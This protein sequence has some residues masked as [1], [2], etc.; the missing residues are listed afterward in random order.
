MPR[1]KNLK[2]KRIIFKCKA[3][4]TKEYG[5]HERRGLAHNNRNPGIGSSHDRRNHVVARD[6]VITRVTNSS[7]LRCLNYFYIVMALLGN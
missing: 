3:D 1:M 2:I 4:V 7:W 5:G 6:I